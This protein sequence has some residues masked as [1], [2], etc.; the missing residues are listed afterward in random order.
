MKQPS[1]RSKTCSTFRE[2]S[3]VQL[4]LACLQKE[5]PRTMTLLAFRLKKTPA[6]V[7]TALDRLMVK[8]RVTR[9]TTENNQWIWYAK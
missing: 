6:A 3:V 2:P 4:V 9:R 7:G 5:G 8:G 1:T